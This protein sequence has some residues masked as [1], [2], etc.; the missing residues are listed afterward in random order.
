[1]PQSK[2][3]SYYLIKDFDLICVI[4][5]LLDMQE[6]MRSDIE[7]FIEVFAPGAKLD[8]ITTHGNL[9]IRYMGFEWFYPSLKHIPENTYKDLNYTQKG[10][11][12]T[13]DNETE[14]GRKIL[15]EKMGL[16]HHGTV[17]CSEIWYGELSPML[18][19]EI[20]KEPSILYDKDKRIYIL[21]TDELRP[22]GKNSDYRPPMGVVSIDKKRVNELLPHVN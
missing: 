4:K 8:K 16:L 15:E 9:Q 18:G 5:D 2:K 11:V 10:I 17:D 20:S 19:W 12:V 13:L 14:K 22:H 6:S 3:I 7:C 1:M 21:V